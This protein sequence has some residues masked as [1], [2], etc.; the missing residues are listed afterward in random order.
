MAQFVGF[1]LTAAGCY[2][3]QVWLNVAANI[4]LFGACYALVARQG[5]FGAI[6]AMLIGASVQLAGS[7]VVLLASMRKRA[8]Q[9]AHTLQTRTEFLN[10]PTPSETRAAFTIA[11]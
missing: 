10:A 7:I 6:I 11:D 9:L 1:G 8:G 4:A 2:K 5:L 3:P